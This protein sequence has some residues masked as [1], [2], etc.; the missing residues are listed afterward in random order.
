M[1]LLQLRYFLDSARFG[2]I[3][4]AAEKHMVPASSISAAIRRL[5]QEL[6][7]KLFDRSSNRIILNNN[8]RKL[9]DS[10]ETVFSELDQTVN[11]IVYPSDDQII[12]LLALSD[13]TR[14][15]NYIIEYQNKH[16]AVT[17][18]T[19][20]NYGQND[21][22]DYDV[23]IGPADEQYSGYTSLELYKGRI[24]LWANPSHPLFG[25]E[26]T[27][28]QLRD[29]AF[30]TMGSNM[31]HIVTSACQRAGFTPKIVAKVND[32]HCYHTLMRSGLY[33]G[34]IRLAE[35]DP[36][37]PF[38]LNVTDFVEYQTICV[39]YKENATGSIKS[40]LEF[41]KTKLL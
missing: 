11:D 10:L 1:E 14:I 18:D 8:G 5:E 41:L 33:I 6:G 22:R 17:F 9:R 27:L 15:T 16:P 35:Q 23:I 40:F 34:H 38:C 29:Q 39:Y 26:L 24:Y 32:I 19:Y 3:A 28:R 36:L 4:R 31:H 37:D 20:I 7:Q 21:I 30:V 2:S 25:K 12:R 13:R